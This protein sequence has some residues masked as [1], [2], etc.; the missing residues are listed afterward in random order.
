MSP[1]EYKKIAG[2]LRLGQVIAY[3]T[4]GVFGLGCDPLKESA[5]KKLLNLKQR[6]IEK[7]LIVIAANWQQLTSW[8]GEL[9]ID[10]IA[11]IYAEDLPPITWSV[12]ASDFVPEWIRGVHDTVAVRV[13]QHDVA[14]KICLAFGGPIVSTSANLSGHQ[15]CHSYQEVQEQLGDEIDYIV[16][17]E[18]GNLAKP[19]PIY[20]ALTGA[21]LRA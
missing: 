1:T 8:M 13:T 21:R 16:K 7:G 3:P 11:A 12:P 14:R 19:T 17:A 10:R 9:P 2:L 5:V 20:D 4:E 15:P 6:S 18:T